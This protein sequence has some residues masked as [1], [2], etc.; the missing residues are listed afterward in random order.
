LRTLQSVVPRGFL[1]IPP[2]TRYF[3][4]HPEIAKLKKQIP[5]MKSQIHNRVKTRFALTTFIGAWLVAHAVSAS[6]RPNVVILYGDD[7]GYGDVGVYGSKKIPTPHLDRLAAEGLRFT[8]AHCS[9]S[10]CTPSRYSLLTGEMPFRKEGTGIARGDA[11]RIIS[12]DQFTL[13]D[14]F[15]QSGYQTAVIGK[16]HLGLG[17][18]TIDWNGKITPGPES[19]G[20]DRY[21]IIPA[22]NDRTPCVYVADGQVVNLD[23]TDPITVSYRGRIP[24][25]VPGTTYPDG[26]LNPEAVT[27]YKGDGYHSAT[28]I[29]G[30]GRIGYMKGGKR[31]LFKDENIADDL[32]REAKAFITASKDAPFF[33]FFS[34]SDIHAPRWPHPRFRGK[35]Q[36]GLRGDAMVSFDWSVGEITAMLEEL[37]LA[38]NT[39]VIATSDNGPVYID[40]GYQDGCETGGSSGSDHG[41]DASGIYR[42]GKY[43]IYEGGNRVPFI[44]RWPGKVRVGQSDALLSQVDLLASFAAMVGGKIP[45]GQAR[46]SR[47]YLGALLGDENDGAGIILECSPGEV[48][49]RHGH[50]K[51]I[52][53][54]PQLYDLSEDPGET[55]NLLERFPEAAREMKELLEESRTQPLG[56]KRQPKPLTTKP[57]K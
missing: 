13:A 41:H 22:T 25:A 4:A 33:L 49:I 51:Y 40:G 8:D 45:P 24:D 1:D 27:A 9:A 17:E 18:G 37:G 52:A 46:D 50:W 39:L 53:E 29:N 28:V 44:A 26:R 43:Q 57:T 6:E 48:A 20:F 21:F 31:A 30:L 34:A 47:N 10:T 56:E 38:E 5:D 42:G 3:A 14:V 54:P 2:G 36:H 35:S 7:V 15:R 19:L 32:V 23:P 11:S 12:P 55:D 16:W